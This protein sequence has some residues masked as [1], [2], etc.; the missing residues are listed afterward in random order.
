MVVIKKDGLKEDW[1]NQKIIDAIKKASLRCESSIT[2]EQ[3]EEV[4]NKVF[5][6]VQ[7]LG[8]VHTLDLHSMV[9]DQL[10]LSGFDKI[11]NAYQEYRDYKN[12]YAK[13]WEELKQQTDNILYLGDR[14]NANFDSS[15][16]STKGSL[17]KGSLTKELYKQ[18]YLSNTEKTLIK[19]GDIYIHDL[20]DMIYGSV[21]CCLFDFETVL[22]GGFDMCNV[23]YTEPTSVAS[24]IQV[25][26][27]ITLVASSQQFGG[28]TASE[29]D[30][31]LLP[32][33]KKSLEKYKKEAEEYNVE[34]K[35]QYIDKHVKRELE[36]GFQG[37]ELK[38]NTVVSAR[39]DFP[40]TTLSFGQFDTSLDPIDKYWLSE[41]GLAILNTRM[42]GHSGKQAVFPKLVYLY[43]ENQVNT[44]DYSK[45]LF[46]KA[47]ECSAK[48]M[49]PDWLSLTG[50]PEVNKVA[51]EY[52]T[53][54]KI[55]SPMGMVA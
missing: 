53:Y 38:L 9:I 27:D 39:G 28:W 2:K 15:L 10:K 40:F 5:F 13:N 52:K 46:N 1:N 37:L 11:A 3:A 32:Y 19:R 21:N 54:A 18:F 55:I 20:R 12:T 31:V 25:I 48:C 4:A 45:K 8:N 22:K 51:Q 47:V 23:H 6:L 17:I 26:G 41:I 44:D 42:K 29:I 36:Q 49:Y 33:V 34:F 43:D 24:A 50:S 16:I 35:D 14:E 30:K 7:K